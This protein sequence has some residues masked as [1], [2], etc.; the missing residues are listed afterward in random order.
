MTGPIYTCQ[1]CDCAHRDEEPDECRQCGG[2][3][4][5]WS[6]DY[7]FQGRFA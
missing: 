5:E 4:F 3:E 2:T 7:G 6:Y 1:D